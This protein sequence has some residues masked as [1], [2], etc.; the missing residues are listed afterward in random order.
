G[1]DIA[2]YISRMVIQM[3]AGLT[4][5]DKCNVLLQNIQGGNNIG[6]PC[7]GGW[8]HDFNSL[9]QFLIMT[10]QHCKPKFCLS[11]CTTI[12]RPEG[13]PFYVWS[14]NNTQLVSNTIKRWASLTDI[15]KIL[16]M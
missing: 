1:H 4:D 9:Q 15:E 7:S 12:I 8:K 6:D 14:A 11:T 2:T 16:V 3:P 13:Q 5:T 10:Y